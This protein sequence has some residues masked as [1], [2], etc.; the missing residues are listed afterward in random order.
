MKTSL[1]TSLSVIGVLAT[2]GVAMAVNTTVLNSSISAVNGT[3]ALA[4]ANVPVSALSVDSAM[5]IFLPNQ[6]DALPAVSEMIVTSD[7]N[8]EGV[9]VVTLEQS[10]TGLTVASI[11][12][13]AGWTYDS[14]AEDQDRVEIEFTN[15]TQRIEFRA[16]LIDGRIVTAVESTDSYIA[17]TQDHNDD[18]TNDGHS[19]NE[20]ETGDDD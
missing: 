15:G 4:E 16:E 12:P 8:V 7:Y 19:N 3:P 10:A 2:G 18:E 20:L 13:L 17:S 14:K 1:A 11:S 9:G 5:P 6:G